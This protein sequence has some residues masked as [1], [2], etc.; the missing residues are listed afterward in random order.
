M[1]NLI[2]GVSILMHDEVPF[3]SAPHTFL[4]VSTRQIHNTT[5]MSY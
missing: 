4:E 1:K 3:Q 2:F 5:N